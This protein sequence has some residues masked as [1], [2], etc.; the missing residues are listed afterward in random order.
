MTES[1]KNKIS[2]FVEQQSELPFKVSNI[3][4]MLHFIQGSH[5]DR[6]KEVLVE[7]FD[8][9]TKHHHDN[10]YHIEGWKTNSH[11][12]INKKMIIPVV[13]EPRYNDK[14]AMSMNYHGNT[15]KLNDLTKALCYL[16]GQNYDDFPSLDS[17]IDRMPI[18]DPE[19][20]KNNDDIKESAGKRYDQLTEQMSTRDKFNGQGWTRDSWIQH[21]IEEAIEKQSHSTTRKF[22]VWHE[23][24][25]FEVK[26]FKKGTMHFKFKDD[27]VWEMFN[28]AVA[29]AKGFELP[30]HVAFI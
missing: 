1:L 9:F 18:T 6:M 19:Y 5:G 26:G 22:A 4:S 16:T 11:Y 30:E 15:A 8:K 25:F 28:R 13:V 27:K 17:W 20:Y 24:G 23:W 10:R 14:T 7:V 29:D 12:M 3:Y 2:Q 21:K